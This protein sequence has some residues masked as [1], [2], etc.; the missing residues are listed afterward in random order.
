MSGE[1]EIE[2]D[3]FVDSGDEWMDEWMVK[4]MGGY[5]GDGDLPSCLSVIRNEN[6]ALDP[7]PRLSVCPSGCFILSGDRVK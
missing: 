4:S 3:L 1:V 5:G 6:S 7:F 2:A